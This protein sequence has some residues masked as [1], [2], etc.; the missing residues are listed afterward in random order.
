MSEVERTLKKVQ[1]GVELFDTIWEKV[2]NAQGQNQKEKYEMDLKKEIKKLQ[3]HR[4]QIKNWIASNDIKD[5]S[6]LLAA[7]KL[8]E[9][10]MEQ[11]KV[12]EKET[13]TKAYSKEG[14]AQATKLDPAEIAKNKTRDW[15]SEILD[16]LNTQNEE[17]E[18][19][20]E[21]KT[22]AGGKKN[23]FRD[24]I[25]NL[26]ALCKRNLWHVTKLEVVI[27]LMD[28][29]VLSIDDIDP[30]KDD[31]DYYLEANTEQ[32]FL[33]NYGDD[34][35]YEELDLDANFSATTASVVSSSSSKQQEV[36]EA[37]AP[38]P[39]TKKEEKKQA[40]K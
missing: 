32:D 3:R 34:D 19:E 30:L 22:S 26:E 16:Q 23:K 29:D 6:T 33:D 15:I 18:S 27:R 37:P 38:A 12:C 25:E 4:D 5:K 36:E 10:K 2:Y 31:L 8:V 14:L 21:A 17:F 7:R 28:N 20:I 39:M 13:K 40:K 9:T 11:F 35:I 24:E 1:E